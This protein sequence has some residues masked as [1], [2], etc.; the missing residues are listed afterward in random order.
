MWEISDL[1]RLHERRDVRC[2]TFAR[3]CLANEYFQTWFPLDPV[4]KIRASSKRLKNSTIFH[5]R[6]VL[7]QS[8]VRTLMTV[9]VTSGR[10]NLPRITIFLFAFFLHWMKLSSL[11]A[12]AYNM[13]VLSFPSFFIAICLNVWFL[14]IDRPSSGKIAI[15]RLK[16]E[17]EFEI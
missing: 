14:L 2:E 13:L 6:R 7:A 10:S 11:T 8:A 12:Y 3:E 9:Y 16:P 5:L 17:S 1:K 15:L 4:E